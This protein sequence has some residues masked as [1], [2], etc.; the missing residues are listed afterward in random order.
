MLLLVWATCWIL[1]TLSRP[2]CSLEISGYDSNAVICSQ[3]LSD[4]IMKDVMPLPAEEVDAVDV[5]NL[6]P[7]IKLCCNNSALCTLCLVIDTEICV[8]PDKDME[9]EYHSG[10]NEETKETK[11]SVTLCYYAALKL[12]TCKKVEF[13]INLRALTQESQ[14][15]MSMVIIKP[16]RISFSSEV[17][18]YDSKS[19]HLRQKIVFP[20]LKEVCLEQQK[21]V[22]ECNPPS[23]T[24]VIREEI[25]SVELQF[26]GSSEHLPCVCIQYEQNGTCQRWNRTTIPLYSVT[27][28][29]CL[30][31][32]YEDEDRPIRTQSCPFRNKNVVQRNIWQ[33][34]SVS[35]DQGK[36]NNNEAMLLWNLSAPCR[37]EGEVW[38][39]HIRSSCWEIKGFKQQLTHGTW[40]QNSKGF[41]EKKGVFENI[42]LQ[43][44]PC[45]MVKIKGMAHE[46]GPFCF[47]NT[48]RFRWTLLVVGVL[49]L[50]C[51]TLLT[52][53]FLHGYVKKWVWSWHHGGFVKIGQ[54]GHVVLLS[55]PDVDEGV[56][57]LVSGLG[58]LL[59]TQG[60]RVSVDQWSR[61]D[62]CKL[63]PLPW[64][65]SQLLE[66]NSRV[67]LVLSHKAL[68]R[69][70]ELA[71]QHKEVIKAKGENKG[72]PKIL[73]PYSD[74]FTASLCIIQ[75][76]KQLGRTGERF[77]LVKFDS[78]Q[79]NDK[80]LPVLLQ[81]L[82][83][84][85]L[86]S[87]IQALLAELSVQRTGSRYSRRTW[88]DWKCSVSDGWNPAEYT[89]M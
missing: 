21:R 49:L 3:G 15:K 38:P 83:L 84:F 6:T 55:P 23:I 75:T 57:K 18:V 40:K 85:Q 59:H 11:A 79:R 5:H 68:E 26:P 87:Q 8:N 10:F 29:M 65:H 89:T 62:Q 61:R 77:I 47:N 74:M 42:N 16:D 67:V 71:H 86:P 72:I 24:T 82:P 13:T 53:Y 9:D 51:L 17:F 4:C 32:W 63:G 88:I 58:S 43:F 28:C 54:E 33:N 80:K 76:E 20:S 66:Q 69:M 27:H 7:H 44:S 48:D 64:F 45:V 56:S 36:M 73:S 70:E 30:Q 46:L 81:G 31:V 37:L 78:N 1:L 12:P 60:F 19:S 39:C 50:I 41:W 22:K 2:T 34:V 25:S 14:A 52:F 35:I